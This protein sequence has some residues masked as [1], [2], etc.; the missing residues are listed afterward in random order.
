[1][2]KLLILNGPVGKML[3]E[4]KDLQVIRCLSSQAASPAKVSMT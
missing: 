3:S 1:M 2:H 4:E